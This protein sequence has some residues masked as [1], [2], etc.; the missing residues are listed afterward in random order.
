MAI[1]VRPH[2][3]GPPAHGAYCLAKLCFG[4]AKFSRPEEDL[5][6]FGEIHSPVV[7]R[8]ALLDQRTAGFAH[9]DSCG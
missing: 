8:A 7:L 1:E 4:A 2:V 5:P 6:G 3:P 9:L